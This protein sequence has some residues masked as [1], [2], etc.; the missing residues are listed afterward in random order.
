MIL[1]SCTRKTVFIF[2]LKNQLFPFIRP[3]ELCCPLGRVAFYCAEK[4]K[5]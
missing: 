4:G 5:S 1:K 2:T 3:L